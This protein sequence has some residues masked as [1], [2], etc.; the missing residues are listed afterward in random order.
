VSF[1]I[2]R[3]F[4]LPKNVFY[5]LF[6]LK[7]FNQIRNLNYNKVQLSEHFIYNLHVYDV[8]CIITLVIAPH[9]D[10]GYDR[11]P[12]LEGG[13]SHPPPG[14]GD[15]A[16]EWSLGARHYLGALL[17]CSRWRLRGCPGSSGARL[18]GKFFLHA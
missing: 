10:P 17:I 7:L 4:S 5:S 9:N 3:V 1:L 12:L 18:L 15:T 6:H 16:R 13:T 8:L 2:R 11:A 14:C